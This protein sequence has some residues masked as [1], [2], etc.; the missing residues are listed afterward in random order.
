[1]PCSL[2]MQIA[3]SLRDRVARSSN[4]FTVHGNLQS[5]RNFCS[6]K[7]ECQ[8]TGTRLM[9]PAG[10]ARIAHRTRRII[11]SIMGNVLAL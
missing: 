7:I 4:V 9:A 3:E 6:F 5:R 2:G 11:S 10:S 8:S 1:M